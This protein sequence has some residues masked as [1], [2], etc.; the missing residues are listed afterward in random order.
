MTGFTVKR[1]RNYVDNNSLEKRNNNA[2]EVTVN[3]K[4]LLQVLL[5]SDDD[6]KG[7]KLEEKRLDIALKRQKLK[8]ER[9]EIRA[10]E[11]EAYRS[12]VSLRLE[13]L[14]NQLAKFKSEKETAELLMNSIEESKAQIDKTIEVY[15]D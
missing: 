8:A 2:S 6:E 15:E 5:K 9:D 1:L 3:I 14:K 4:D 10:E 11:R 12:V 7:L 13:A